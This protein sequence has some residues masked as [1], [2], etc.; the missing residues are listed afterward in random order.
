MSLSNDF[1]S[2]ID[3]QNPFFMYLFPTCCTLKDYFLDYFQLRSARQPDWHKW[4]CFCVSERKTQ[5][6]NG[7]WCVPCLYSYHW[8]SWASLTVIKCGL[9]RQ[10]R[11][12]RCPQWQFIMLSGS[13]KMTSCFTAWINFLQF[14][15]ATCLMV[16]IEQCSPLSILSFFE[17]SS[18]L[19]VGVVTKKAVVN[20][21][22]RSKQ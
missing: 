3:S 1:F 4:V 16:E 2:H 11:W 9:P 17:A 6:K 12:S 5:R 10:L 21:I 14:L 15:T 7:R 20:N 19:R 13:T 22:N 8:P 18:Q